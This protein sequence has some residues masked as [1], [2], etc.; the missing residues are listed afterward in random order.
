MPR[1]PLS[2]MIAPGQLASQG[3]RCVGSVV[4]PPLTLP[5][6]GS[7]PVPGPYSP[8][9][10]FTPPG[11]Y[12]P[13]ATYAPAA[14]RTGG[15]VFG[16]LDDPFVSRPGALPL[17][18]SR[19]GSLASQA[20]SYFETH[21]SGAGYTQA[22][23]QHPYDSFVGHYG[24]YGSQADRV[25]VPRSLRGVQLPP[26]FQSHGALAHTSITRDFCEAQR[27]AVKKLSDDTS[28]GTRMLLY[29]LYQQALEGDIFGPRPSCC[30]SHACKKYDAWA[31]NKGMRRQQ[32]MYM[33]IKAVS[34]ID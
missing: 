33:Y 7:G 18:G 4:V 19:R 11:T 32:A 9:G 26:G 15:P 20:P 17:P 21:H 25:D 29:G 14:P 22:V 8:G 34:L 24:L 13:A 28:L 5:P 3:G 10:H 31:K 1:A 16:G 6:P 23:G 30:S 2:A 12:G 27:L